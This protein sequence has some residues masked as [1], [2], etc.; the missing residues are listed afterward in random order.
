M[1]D[2]QGV[3]V[4]GVRR[5]G[6]TA[7]ID[8]GTNTFTMSVVSFQ[9]T[10][11]VERF[12]MRVPV[13]LGSG[14]FKAGVIRPERFARGVDAMRVLQEAARNYGVERFVAL[15]TSALRDASN[16]GEFLEGVERATGIRVEVIDGGQEAALI[17]RGVRRT[18][19]PGWTG[20]EPLLVVDIGGGSVETVL[21]V[22]DEVRWWHS[23][24]WGVARLREWAAPPEPLGVDGREKL[25]PFLDSVLAPLHEAL[26]RWKPRR[27]VGASGFFETL[28]DMS[29]PALA[30][31]PDAPREVGDCFMA[32]LDVPVW[33]GIRDQL[34]A[35]DLPGRMALPG[36]APER[37]EFMPLAAVWLDHLLNRMTQS[38]GGEV[39]WAVSPFSL[40]EG[41]LDV[42]SRGEDPLGVRFP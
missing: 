22:G 23:F 4:E 11:W 20:S 1:A 13:R 35:L 26:A 10:P 2:V 28:L 30:R 32:T 34:W 6:T 40:R 14:G 31:I 5:S 27:L 25:E 38:T 3:M 15:G 17:W 18:L 21:V 29:R 41:V 42:L 7:V 16:R 9:V 12:A 33:E 37:A 39:A 19:L 24:D 36:M 8:C